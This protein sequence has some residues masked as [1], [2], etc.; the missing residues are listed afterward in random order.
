MSNY[1]QEYM[2]HIYEQYN[3]SPSPEIGFLLRRVEELEAENRRLGRAHL[4]RLSAPGDVCR[5][6]EH[7]PPSHIVLEP[8]MWR[9][10]C[11][12]CGRALEF[13]VGGA[14]W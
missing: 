2:A 8:G 11:P 10:T 5:S 14:T 9:W 4:E 13:N 3:M 6:P 12:A 7:E 1:Q